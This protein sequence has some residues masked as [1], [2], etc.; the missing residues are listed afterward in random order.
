MQT[1]IKDVVKINHNIS[2]YQDKII[3]DD[4]FTV[5][6]KVLPNDTKDVTWNVRLNLQASSGYFDI[7][8]EVKANSK[9]IEILDLKLKANSFKTPIDKYE[10]KAPTEYQDAKKVFVPTNVEKS[11]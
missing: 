9:N 4:S 11:K 5:D 3:I 8:L 10:I 6:N 7:D 2:L 1:E